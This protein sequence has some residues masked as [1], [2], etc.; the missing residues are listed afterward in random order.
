MKNSPEIEYVLHT[1]FS[2]Q[3]GFSEDVA[4]ELYKRSRLNNGKTEALKSE[5]EEAFD[6]S[7]FSW[8]AILENPDCEYYYAEDEADAR[9]YAK[10][11]LWDPIFGS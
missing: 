7:E 9:A 2:S 8:R 5:L 3:E 10:K 6:N 4:I 1:M 11:I